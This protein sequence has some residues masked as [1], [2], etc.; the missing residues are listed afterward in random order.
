VTAAERN[1]IEQGVL[2]YCRGLDRFDRGLAL[3]P[4]APDA[5]LAYSEIYA[6][7]APG[8][9]DWAWSLHATLVG[10]VH[11]VANVFIERNPSGDLVSESYV[12]TTLRRLDG[13]E[14]L[15]RVAYGRYIDRWVR[16]GGRLVIAERDYVTDVVRETRNALEVPLAVTTEPGI[17]ARL[18]TRDT[19]D[20]SHRLLS[21]SA[22]TGS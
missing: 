21:G 17:D 13:D 8:F 12:A 1:L 4:F 7:D 15:D 16:R 9:M 6:G 11:R 20:A 19:A 3:S 2:A 10:H 14:H 22:G 18:S 5:V